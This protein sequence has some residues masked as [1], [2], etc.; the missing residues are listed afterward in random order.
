G[1]KGK[2][3][4]L[5]PANPKVLGPFLQERLIRSR[6]WPDITLAM[7]TNASFTPVS[8]SQANYSLFAAITVDEGVLHV[9]PAG[10]A[11]SER[12]ASIIASD[13][14]AAMDRLGN[15]FKRMVLDLSDVQLMSSFGLGMCIELRHTAQ[16]R[17][18]RT[19]LYGL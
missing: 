7:T 1:E 2:N 17:G 15:Q 6:F 8:S 18:V 12:E 19:V 5:I 9:R 4:L 14:I 11:L 16:R 10:P 3:L 13:V